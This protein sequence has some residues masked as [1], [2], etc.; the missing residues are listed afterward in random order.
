M[1]AKCLETAVCIDTTMPYGVRMVQQPRIPS[2]ALSDTGKGRFVKGRHV[3]VLERFD[4]TTW[5]E[6]GRFG[7]VTDA[8]AALDAAVAAGGD[9]ETLRITDIGPTMTGRVALVIGVVL[10]VA[11]AAF[12]LYVFFAG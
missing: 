6:I 5:L 8:G 10:A 9:P 3:T 11:I 1:I 2:P 7:S 4:G 12:V